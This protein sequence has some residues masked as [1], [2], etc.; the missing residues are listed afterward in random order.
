MLLSGDHPCVVWLLRKDETA[1]TER[2]REA[3][4]PSDVDGRMPLAEPEGEYVNV[5]T[6][7]R[8]DQQAFTHHLKKGNETA[9]DLW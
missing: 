9:Y 6:L 2:E 1:S 3:R 8:A 4:H 5:I 7:A